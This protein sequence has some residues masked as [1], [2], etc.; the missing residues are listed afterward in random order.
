MDEVSG[1]ATPTFAISCAS[2]MTLSASLVKSLSG[3]KMFPSDIVALRA[4]LRRRRVAGVLGTNGQDLRNRQ[5][6]A[7]FLE[8]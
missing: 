8:L 7:G 6:T 4:A 5:I 2:G 3:L 1:V